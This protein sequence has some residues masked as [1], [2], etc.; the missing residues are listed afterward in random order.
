M[1]QYP[2]QQQ[3]QQQTWKYTQPAVPATTQSSSTKDW[4]QFVNNQGITNWEEHLRS[5]GIDPQVWQLRSLLAVQGR[6]RYFFG[7]CV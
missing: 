2:T 1:A 7:V 5:Q 4:Q 6:S 3:Q